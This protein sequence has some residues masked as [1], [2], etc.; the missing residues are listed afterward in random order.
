MHG[1]LQARKVQVQV[2][3]LKA[4]FSKSQRSINQLLRA[5]VFF[6]FGALLIA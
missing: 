2:V 5:C 6:L 1:P 4:K 3:M